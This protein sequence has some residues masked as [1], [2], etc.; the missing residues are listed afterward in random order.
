MFV[1]PKNDRKEQYSIRFLA[2]FKERNWFNRLSKWKFNYKIKKK[3][4]TKNH[5]S[6]FKKNI[7]KDLET[8]ETIK[9]NK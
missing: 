6:F 4:G 3:Q 9:Q 2:L 7:L 8:N 1:P 5:I